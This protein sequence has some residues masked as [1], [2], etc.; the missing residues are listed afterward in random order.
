MSHGQ[1]SSFFF[2]FPLFKMK[3]WQLPSLIRMQIKLGQHQGSS[4]ASLNG[5]VGSQNSSVYINQ[6][7]FWLVM[8]MPCNWLRYCFFPCL[9]LLHLRT[10][11]MKHHVH[12]HVLIYK[13]ILPATSV[14]KD[15]LHQHQIL[16]TSHFKQT[17][18]KK[19]PPPQNPD[20]TYL[21]L[22][23]CLMWWKTLITSRILLGLSSILEARFIQAMA[24]T[25]KT[26][27]MD[28]IHTA[29]PAPFPT[30]SRMCANI[31]LRCYG[32]DADSA[33]LW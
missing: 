27:P 17:K 8:S 25:C 5:K 16:F 3:N 12:K 22:R 28:F 2:S 31:M 21:L 20:E 15:W 1:T 19:P 33:A 18:Q 29:L 26:T 10:G 7:H 23:T 9:C 13:V 6:N 32:E 24:K 4:T 11:V 14:A 30:Q